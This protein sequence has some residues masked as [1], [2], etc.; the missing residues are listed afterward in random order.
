MSEFAM[1]SL[2][3][4]SLLKF[5]EGK[6]D[7]TIK[8]NLR[9]LYGRR[10]APSDTYMRERNDKVDPRVDFKCVNK[11]CEVWPLNELAGIADKERAVNINNL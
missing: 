7:R 11:F 5:Y 4:P 2:K 1:F 3:F 9:T 10:Q 8:H 6:E